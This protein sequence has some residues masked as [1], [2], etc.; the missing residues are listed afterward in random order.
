MRKGA[1]LS[2]RFR[3]GKKEVPPERERPENGKNS[4]FEL[5]LGLDAFLKM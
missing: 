3:E 4:R 5:D 1:R 2:Q